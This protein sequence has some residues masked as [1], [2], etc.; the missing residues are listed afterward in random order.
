MIHT[1]AVF[2]IEIRILVYQRNVSVSKFL[3]SNVFMVTKAMMG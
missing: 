1:S 3:L 2:E